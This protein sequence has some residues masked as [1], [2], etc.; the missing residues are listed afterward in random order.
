MD[1]NTITTAEPV[2]AAAEEVQTEPTGAAADEATVEA[3]E[4]K[5]TE[6]ADEED[7]D[8]GIDIEN[9]YV[10]QQPDRILLQRARERGMTVEEYSDYISNLENEAEITRLMNEEGFTREE[11]IREAKYK[12]TEKRL[13]AFEDNKRRSDRYASEMR[14]FKELFPDVSTKKIPQEVWDS[15]KAGVDLS[16][17]YAKYERRQ[18]LKAAKAE[19]VNAQT[20]QTAAP[21][22]KQSEKTERYFTNEEIAKMSPSEV[23]KNY[24]AII[25]SM[26]RNN[27]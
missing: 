17:A 12:L 27:K 7:I 3:P 14:E 25:K 24:D 2:E 10:D 26:N 19:K 4:E 21:K 23:R 11:A 5:A 8:I 16:S 13:K 6:S 22:I 18:A 15:V 20:Q 1:D 9:A